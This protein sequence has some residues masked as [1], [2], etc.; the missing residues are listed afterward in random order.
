MNKRQEAMER[1]K[2]LEEEMRAAG[3]LGESN[4]SKKK[5]KKTVTKKRE[6]TTWIIP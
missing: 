4:K 5:K 1:S 3:T 2:K 6:A